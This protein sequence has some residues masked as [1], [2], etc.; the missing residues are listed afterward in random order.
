M[1]NCPHSSNTTTAGSDALLLQWGAIA[2]TAMPAA[3]TKISA[4]LCAN[5][6]AVQSESFTLPTP[7]RFTL[8]G[9]AALSFSA[10]ARP[11]R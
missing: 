8:P 3:P 6:C 9:Y 1:A 10:R 4:L 7:Q 5:C 11:F 2:R